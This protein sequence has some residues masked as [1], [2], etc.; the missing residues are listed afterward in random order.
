MMWRYGETGVDHMITTN[1]AGHTDLKAR[2]LL[3]SD[4]M[5]LSAPGQ[6]N[7]LMRWVN[8]VVAIGRYYNQWFLSHQVHD[9]LPWT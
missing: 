4:T 1:N 2:L 5:Y 3:A 9:T 7:A 8:R 6:T